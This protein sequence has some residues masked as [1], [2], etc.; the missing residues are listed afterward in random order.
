MESVHVEI[1]DDSV[2]IDNGVSLISIPLEEARE[3][4][5]QMEEKLYTKST[6]DNINKDWNY[7]GGL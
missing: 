5:K 7:R 2:D 1:T 3:F 4:I 6:E